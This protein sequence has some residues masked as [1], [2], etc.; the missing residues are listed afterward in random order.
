MVSQAAAEGLPPPI[1]F[2]LGAR[3]HMSGV[4]HAYTRA[5]VLRG[6]MQ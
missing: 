2:A 3:T 5:L 1:R 6:V 4:V